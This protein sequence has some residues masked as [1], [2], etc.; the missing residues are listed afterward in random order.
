MLKAICFD[1]W[2]TLI[3][4]RSFRDE[5][6]KLT[7]KRLKSWN[8]SK[9]LPEI[10]KAYIMSTQLQNFPQ[11][12]STFRHVQN[13]TRINVLCSE[14]NIDLT[15]TQKKELSIEFEE[16]GLSYPPI[17]KKG[18]SELLHT[19]SKQ[20]KIGLISDTGYTTGRILRQILDHYGILSYFSAIVFSDELDYY[21]PHSLPFETCLNQLQITPDEAVHIGDL[22][23]T[24][25]TGAIQFGMHA[26]WI[27]NAEGYPLIQKPEKLEQP[28]YT[29]SHVTE[30]LELLPKF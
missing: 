15:E 13:L 17:L 26:I 19:L 25:V 3:D 20:Y 14:L 18:V 9:S 21:K 6:V 22:L 30:I 4:N 10:S 24:D 29:V 28:D 12:T 11:N 5:R 23:E 8:I 2:N 1:L 16:V 7:Q 27:N